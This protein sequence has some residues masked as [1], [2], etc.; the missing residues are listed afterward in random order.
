MELDAPIAQRRK[1]QGLIACQLNSQ[2]REGR[3]FIQHDAINACIE[4]KEAVGSPLLYRDVK[5]EGYIGVDFYMNLL[6]LSLT[7]A[8][9]MRGSTASS[10]SHKE[11]EL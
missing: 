4:E 6:S 11:D 1:H 10:C 2:K 7:Y 3:S 8:R 5:F 9:E